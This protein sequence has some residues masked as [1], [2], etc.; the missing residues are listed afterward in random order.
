M[1]KPHKSSIEVYFTDKMHR[2]MFLFPESDY[3]RDQPNFR[4]LKPV[5]VTA[6]PMRELIRKAYL[7]RQ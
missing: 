6:S 5:R 4:L 7:V 1:S 2:K 3:E